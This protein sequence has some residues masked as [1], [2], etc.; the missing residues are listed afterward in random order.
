ML[1][2]AGLCFSYRGPAGAGELRGTEKIGR[3]SE[4]LELGAW[5]VSPLVA[6]D[7]VDPAFLAVNPDH[8]VVGLLDGAILIIPAILI[9]L[10]A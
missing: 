3:L 4:P 1:L 10:D 5:R 8:A 2:E 7:A 6:A 9:I